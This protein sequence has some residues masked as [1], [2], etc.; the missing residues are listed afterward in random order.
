MYIQINQSASFPA[1]GEHCKMNHQDPAAPKSVKGNVSWRFCPGILE[2]LIGKP[3]EKPAENPRKTMVS[4][5]LIGFSWDF[6]GIDPPAMTS[7]L[8]T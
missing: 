4:Y 5:G 1:V 6:N 2:G 8:R 3:W 7:S